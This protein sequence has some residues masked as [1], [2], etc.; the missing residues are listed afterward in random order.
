LARGGASGGQEGRRA[1]EG[2][3][4]EEEGKPDRRGRPISEKEGGEAGTD[5]ARGGF[6]PRAASWSGPE[7]RPRPFSLFFC[8]FFSFFCF[9]VCFIT[10]AKLFQNQS[11]QL[12]NFSKIKDNVLRQ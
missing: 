11:N 9:L 7:R 4:P 3:W 1:G 12:L 5:S 8:Y 2:L 10:F 6:G